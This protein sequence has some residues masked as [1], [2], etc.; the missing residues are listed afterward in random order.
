[1]DENR[2]Y[3]GY[4]IPTIHEEIQKWEDQIRKYNGVSDGRIC[5]YR[6]SDNMPIIVPNL[7]CETVEAG[8]NNTKDIQYN[9]D[10]I[11]ME[12]IDSFSK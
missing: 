7:N 11:C 12:F 9:L 4:R 8:F 3:K 6:E 5:V 1:M 10:K 2:I